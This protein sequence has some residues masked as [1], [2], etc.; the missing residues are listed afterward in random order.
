VWLALGVAF[1]A[2]L[3]LVLRSLGFGLCLVRCL[4]SSRFGRVLGLLGLFGGGGWGFWCALLA[5]GVSVCF[6]ELGC[7]RFLLGCVV[8]SLFLSLVVGLGSLW[9]GY[10]SRCFF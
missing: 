5:F 10:W 1:A 6:F 7:V 4:A 9:G 2:S 3:V 8:C